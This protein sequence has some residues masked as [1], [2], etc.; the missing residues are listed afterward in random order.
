MGPR[1]AAVV[2]WGEATEMARD[3]ELQWGHGCAAVV[4][5]YQCRYYC[6]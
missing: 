3:E 4:A 6:L 5:Q 1:L 2:A